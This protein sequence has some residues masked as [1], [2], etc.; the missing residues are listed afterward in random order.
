MG[1]IFLGVGWVPVHAMRCHAM[2]CDA[3]ATRET[4]SMHVIPS[5]IG[6][7]KITPA[8]SFP[9]PPLS[10]ENP[11]K[12]ENRITIPTGLTWENLAGKQTISR[13]NL[14]VG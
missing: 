14:G 3:T 1:L 12:G 6:P 5:Y 10:P 8:S 7:N 4:R 9:P 11:Q 2:P 13:L